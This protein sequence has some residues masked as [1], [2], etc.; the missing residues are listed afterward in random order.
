VT[1]MSIVWVLALAIST[2][3][4]T[5]SAILS[6]YQPKIEERF[7]IVGHVLKE[8]GCDLAGFISNIWNKNS[9][10]PKLEEPKS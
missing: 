1:A 7:P 5:I 2:G 4:P 6:F 3:W 8:L 9:K 10:L